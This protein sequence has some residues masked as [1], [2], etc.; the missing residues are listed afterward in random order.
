[1]SFALDLSKYSAKIDVQ[2]NE[3]IEAVAIELYNRITDKNPVLSGLSRANWNVAANT[4]NLA[5][6][7]RTSKRNITSVRGLR[8]GKD[9]V[10]WITNNLEYVYE[11]EQGSSSKAPQGMVA[12][13]LAEVKAWVRS[14]LR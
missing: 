5:V 2:L 3:V 6:S 14:Q 12:I 4:P 9:N 1:M 8:K 13:S 10:V 7:N 11:L